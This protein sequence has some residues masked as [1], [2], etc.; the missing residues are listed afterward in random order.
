MTTTSSPPVHPRACGEQN[1]T[2]RVNRDCTGSSPRL[3]GTV[4]G[5]G[6]VADSQRFIPALAGNSLDLFRQV[7]ASAVH[8]R[9]CGEQRVY[10]CCIRLLPGSSPRL[11]G[12]DN[13]RILA[14]GSHRFIP[15]LAGNRAHVYADADLT[16]VHPRACGEQ[17]REPKAGW[18]R[19]G[20]SPR[21]RGTVYASLQ[22]AQA[23]RFI[24]AL[25]G[26]RS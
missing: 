18:K 4:H 7:P 1:N 20:S 15:A 21:L 16:P 13:I 24:P 9:A 19:F 3:R 2:R 26:N 22:R 5:L 25:A 11:R 23:S 8:P 14:L 17:E 10:I 6:R 12:T